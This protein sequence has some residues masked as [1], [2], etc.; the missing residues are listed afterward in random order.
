M[1]NDALRPRETAHA[2]GNRFRRCAAQA[3]DHR[4]GH[5]TVVGIPSLRGRGA[6]VNP[7]RCGR[8]CRPRRA[9]APPAPRSRRPCRTTPT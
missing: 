3:G 4:G 1:Y 9:C 2:R 7:P 8:W 5:Q 6:E